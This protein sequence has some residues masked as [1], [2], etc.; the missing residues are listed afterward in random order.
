MRFKRMLIAALVLL[1]TGAVETAALAQGTAPTPT[2]PPSGGT[3]TPA[4]R[5]GKG[6][7]AG[8]RGANPKKKREIK[9]KIRK[10]LRKKIHKP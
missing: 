8:K 4:G 7:Q 5:Q 10:H 9:K 1:F 2:A 3:V 6:P